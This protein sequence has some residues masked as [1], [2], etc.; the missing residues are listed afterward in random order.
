MR[1]FTPDSRCDYACLARA[2]FCQHTLLIG[3]ALA[4]ADPHA[5]QRALIGRIAVSSA[6]ANPRRA[7]AGRPACPVRDVLVLGAELL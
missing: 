6:V 7:C 5:P 4:T 1:S 2:T 3:L